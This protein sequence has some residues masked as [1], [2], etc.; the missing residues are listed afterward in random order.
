[1]AYDL[2]RSIHWLKTLLST[3][4]ADDLRARLASK[5]GGDVRRVPGR[6]AIDQASVDQRWTLFPGD[7]TL[8]RAALLGDEATAAR[9]DHQA[10]QRN[11]EH[12]VGTV[13]VPVGIAGPLRVNGLHAQGDYY[14]P[15]ATTEAAL[16]ASYSRGAL[17]ITE[18]GG[19]AA[20]VLNTGVSR[21]PGFAFHTI[22]ESGHFVGWLMSNV[23]T[24]RAVAEATTRHGK[25]ADVQC[26]IEGSSV[27][28]AFEFTTG[29]AAGQNMVTLATA[30][31]CQHILA[32]S[33][34]TPRYHFLEANMSGDKKASHQS[35]L[36]V[37]GRKVTAEVL[38]PGA[39][40]RSRLHATP[41]GFERY[42]RM[43]AMGGVLSGTIGVQGHFANCLAALYIACGQDAACVA[44]S[45]VG[46]TRFEVRGDDLYAA[47][48]LPNVIVGTVGGGTALPSQRACLDWL[49]LAGAGQANALAEVAAAVAL[50]GELSITAALIAGHFAQAHEALARG[51]APLPAGQTSL[52][53]PR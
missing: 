16:V 28:A 35:F 41:E 47:V 53:D 43:G 2:G 9:H 34:V 49:G 48:T 11:I 31:I 13:K 46:T 20:A 39:L 17:A 27:Y 12:F 32:H 22:A 36:H 10:Y 26:T 14:V 23:D 3:S 45:A 30:A 4:T 42:W 38:V 40:V 51:T 33:P 37:R 5:P 25:L 52:T 1:M 6:S 8:A 21:A 19:C 7:A 18:A 24:L 29:D 15:L 44:E 50:A